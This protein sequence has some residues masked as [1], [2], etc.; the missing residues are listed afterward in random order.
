MQHK[1]QG[2]DAPNVKSAL[3]NKKKK[4]KLEMATGK[5]EDICLFRVFYPAS[6]AK[7]Y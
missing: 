2:I 4:R 5:K 7:T 3:V 1:Y 6:N